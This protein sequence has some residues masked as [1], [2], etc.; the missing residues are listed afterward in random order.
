MRRLP[1][2]AVLFLLAAVVRAQELGPVD[3][4][5]LVDTSASM[6]GGAPGSTTG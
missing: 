5:F 4:I 3:W 2:A 1:F 6:R